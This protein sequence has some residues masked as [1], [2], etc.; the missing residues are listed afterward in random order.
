MISL[1]VLIS[2]YFSFY[3]MMVSADGV[4]NNRR[5]DLKNYVVATS[6]NSANFQLMK[7]SVLM[8]E[9]INSMV[10]NSPSTV[11]SVKPTQIPTSNP[12]FFKRVTK[13]LPKFIPS[14]S[15]SNP[16]SIT[17]FQNPQI[18]FYTPINYFGSNPI[19]TTTTATIPS[20]KFAV[21]NKFLQT[22][23]FHY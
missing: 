15:P 13:N 8:K 9:G 18:R 5:V 3:S 16:P 1:I 6:T 11:V 23:Y 12:P 21:S 20:S 14:C 2:L 4:A 7:T 19:S 22:A 17:S 10:A